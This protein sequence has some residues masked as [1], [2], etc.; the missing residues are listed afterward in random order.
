MDELNKYLS[1]DAPVWLK[2]AVT[3]ALLQEQEKMAKENLTDTSNNNQDARFEEI[4]SEDEML[5]EIFPEDE[6]IEEI[7]PEEPSLV[8]DNK[9]NMPTKYQLLEKY[10]ISSVSAFKQYDCF[11]DAVPDSLFKPD[12][13]GD[14]LFGGT[15]HELMN[16]SSVRVLIRPDE[17]KQDVIRALLKIAE[18]VSLSTD[19]KD[20]AAPEDREDV[21]F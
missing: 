9:V 4:Y 2:Q 14:C 7:F 3:E 18:E 10:L 15:T 8:E 21:P 13:D 1:D 20:K 5:E 11:I 19:F 6:V 12:D 17:S 16:G